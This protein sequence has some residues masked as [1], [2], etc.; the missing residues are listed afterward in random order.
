MPGVR[1]GPEAAAVTLDDGAADGQA[2]AQAAGL[3]RVERLEQE[4]GL[5]LA[6][7]D[8]RVL[9]GDDNPGVL[10]D[11]LEIGRASCRERVFGYV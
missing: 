4:I 2:H 8:A 3:R 7:A 1:G 10:V 5:E 11:G 9:D 6:E